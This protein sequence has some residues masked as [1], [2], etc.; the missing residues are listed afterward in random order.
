MQRGG[1]DGGRRAEVFLHSP[2]VCH[3]RGCPRGCRAMRGGRSGGGTR[4][5]PPPSS[6]ILCHMDVRCERNESL[7]AAKC[8]TGVPGQ[9][10]ACEST[11]IKVRFNKCWMHTYSP[12]FLG[13]HPLLAKMQ[14]IAFLVI[15]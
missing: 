12:P 13:L 3:I 2:L 8:S 4:A 5:I 10:F 11:C 14:E 1:G 15:S 9:E 6:I 7:V